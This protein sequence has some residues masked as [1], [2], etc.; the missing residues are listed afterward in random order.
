MKISKEETVTRLGLRYSNGS[1][2]TDAIIG[3]KAQNGKRPWSAIK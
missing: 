3:R 2:C 1:E